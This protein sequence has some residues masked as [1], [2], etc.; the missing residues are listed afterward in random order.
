[1][2]RRRKYPCQRPK[3]P[4]RAFLKAG[5]LGFAGLA[6]PELLRAEAAVGSRDSTKAVV[7]IHLDGG[8]PHMDLIDLKPDAPVEIRGEFHGI[9]TRVPGLQIC[10]LLPK[11][12]QLADKFV[13]VR[14]LVG[15]A[16]AHDAFQCQ[17]GFA[18]KDLQSLGGRPA[19]GCVVSKL[20]GS[21]ADTSPSFVDL[22]QGRPFVRNSARPGFLGPAYQ[23]F[24][25]DISHLFARELEQGMKGELARRGEYHATS[26]T[27]NEQLNAARVDDRL[28]LLRGFDR[29]RRD[30]DASGMMDA[31]DDFSRQALGILTSG[32][33]SRAM[34]LGQED[35]ATIARYTLEL[36]NDQLGTS[37]GA[38][39]VKKLLLARRLIEA[40]VRCVSLTLSDFDTH[41]GN[42]SRLRYLLPVLDQGLFALATDLE[43]RGMLD[44]V[45][46]VVWG[47][48]GRT[49]RVNG[50]AGRDHWP[51]AGMALLAGGGMRTG[52]VLGATDRHAAAVVSRPVRYQDVMATL[53]RN[54]RIDPVQT[55]LSDPAGRPQYLVDQGQ[56]IGELL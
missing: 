39:A 21:R 55:T 27:L 31:M 13:F 46:I 23:P 30:V 51:A 38:E 18:A 44:D 19:L 12:A 36:P 10:E 24:R 26:F 34:D 41:R 8:P 20:R 29:L 16:G 33:F 25:P 52:Q 32:R 37:D 48:F 40:G 54:L 56:A 22:M 4:R 7:N 49:P 47:E 28:R 43:E 9:E 2:R 35:A 15:S 53:Y 6:L 42:F 17:S 3:L 14:S 11:L 50:G 1:M 5:S 45:S